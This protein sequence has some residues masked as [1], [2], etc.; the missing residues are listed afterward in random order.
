MRPPRRL[1]ELQG[2]EFVFIE[3][4]L[5]PTHYDR[6]IHAGHSAGLTPKIVQLGTNDSSNLSLAAAGLGLTIVPAATELPENVVLVS[7]GDLNVVTT[8]KLVWRRNNRWPAL[9]NF[10]QVLRGESTL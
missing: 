9:K 1:A 8:M 2:Q 3:R 7:V 6:I 4:A 5:N 10:V